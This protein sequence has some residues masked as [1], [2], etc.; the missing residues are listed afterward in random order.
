[1]K[2]E[3]PKP[4]A[5]F[6]AAASAA[7]ANSWTAINGFAVARVY[8]NVAEEYEAARG[9]AVVADFG[10][11]IR[12]SARGADAPAVLARATSAP[13]A[14]LQPGESARGLMLDAEGG[15]VDIVEVA[16]LSDELFLLATPRRHARRLQ[17][18]ARGLDATVEE[19]SGHIAALALIGPEALEIAKAAGFDL[20]GDSLAAQGRVRGV[21][22]SARPIHFGALSGV[23]IIYPEEEA[24]TL[25]E[26]L[27]RARAP[28][29]AGLDA[30]EILRIEGGAPRPGVDFIPADE[31][32]SQAGRRLP[33]ELGLPHLA[34]ANRAWFNGRRALRGAGG[35]ARALAVLAIDADAVPAGA[36]VHAEGRKGAVG[37]LSSL[38]F[39]PRMRR[40]VAFADLG[41]EAAG[42]P[43]EVAAGAGR[44]RAERL[45]TPESRLAAAF[46]AATDSRA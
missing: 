16:R 46:R 14:G 20:A 36:A 2:T 40:V 1:P 23:E 9:G 41:P 13:V 18:A 37:W 7:A 45:E 19:I 24:L 28:R 43:L 39:S 3:D 12:Y 29:P 33:A 34:P 21:E 17:L 5:L 27:R 25:W 10:A 31:A 22:T 4:T 42:R 35:G 26:R 38:A 8:A 6:A 32:R 15:V 11:I 30:L 44:V